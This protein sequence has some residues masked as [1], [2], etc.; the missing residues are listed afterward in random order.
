MLGVDGKEARRIISGVYSH[1]GKG[2]AELIRLPLM[3]DRL[4]ELV[5]LEGD[6]H[7]RKAMGKGRGAIFLSAHIG[8]WEY[9]AALLARK[10]F[11]VNAIGAEQRD[12]RITEAFVKLQ[13]SVGIN[14][15]GKGLNLKR[16]LSCLRDGEILAV[17]LDQDAR[18]SGV[19]SP[20]LGFPASTPIGPIKLAKKF[21]CP[22]LP[23]SVI[24]RD[25]GARFLMTIEPALEGPGGA[26]F[27]EDV[28]Y[29]ADRCNE[30]ISSWIRKTPEQWLWTYPRWASTL[31]DR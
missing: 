15:I 5:S 11:P 1:F 28:Q 10:G 31:G 8:N 21:G 13:R 20:F 22:V 25:N 30:A 4:D 18:K 23:V 24:R 19:I 6:E 16:A 29:A 26:P 27:G 7:L 14:L 12:P 17:L 2:L 3:I 9:G